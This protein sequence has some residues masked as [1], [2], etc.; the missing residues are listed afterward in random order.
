MFSIANL[1]NSVSSNAVNPI[2]IYP[3]MM[4]IVLH[5]YKT[6]CSY[7]C[8]AVLD[9]YLN[10]RKHAGEQLKPG[11]PL[12]REQ[13]NSFDKF[14]VNNPK[15][16]GTSLIRYLVNEVLVKYSALKKKLA[17]DYENKRKV[18][19][20]STM[21]THG[22]RKYFDTEARKAGVYLDFVELLMG[23]KLPGV[24]KHYFKPDMNILLEGTKEVKGYITAIDSL[25]IN[26][27]NRLSK[28]V[29]E[30]KEKDDYQ[31]YVIDKKLNEK[32][33]EI[34][35]L[36][37]GMIGVQ[38]QLDNLVQVLG[39]MNTKNQKFA[40]NITDKF[41]D[42]TEVINELKKSGYYYER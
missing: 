10:Y 12:I 37:N 15:H 33:E 21:L 31:N 6:F 32:D 19:K 17:Y 3:I 42:N 2:R 41:K 18:G 28:Q 35:A 5:H 13:F 22:L 11:S 23:H 27:E 25:T 26:D 39:H 9:S 29:Q 40:K 20:N 24:R 1:Y 38:T 4:S 34:K 7:E 30:L 8:A 14:K 16:I 36:K